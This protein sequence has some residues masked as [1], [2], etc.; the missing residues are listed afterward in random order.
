VS[1]RGRYA[2]LKA[3]ICDGEALDAAFARF[4]PAAVIHLAAR[5]SYRGERL[6]LLAGGATALAAVP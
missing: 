5:R 2:F 6:G 4:K 1:R 3:D